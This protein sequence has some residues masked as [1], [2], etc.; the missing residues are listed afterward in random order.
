MRRQIFACLLGSLYTFIVVRVFSLLRGNVT[1]HH[2]FH[3]LFAPVQSP[4]LSDID[5]KQEIRRKTS[6]SAQ[7]RPQP[8]EKMHMPW[9][10]QT[11]V[12]Y[13]VPVSSPGTTPVN[14]PVQTS[15]KSWMPAE[16]ITSTRQPTSQIN[17]VV[18]NVHFS[19]VGPSQ[20]KALLEEIRIMDE[21][22]TPLPA[23]VSAAP[24]A[25]PAPKPS[26]DCGQ[27][28][29]SGKTLKTTASSAITKPP[30]APVH[31]PVE[32]LVQRRVA[33][34]AF[35]EVPTRIAVS[36]S[37]TVASSGS[38]GSSHSSCASASTSPRSSCSSLV[39]ESVQAADARLHAKLSNI[40]GH[41]Y[42]DKPVV[43]SELN[44]KSTASPPTPSI[45]GPADN[46]TQ[47]VAAP[48][49]LTVLEPVV[50]QGSLEAQFLPI[51][52]E[53]SVPIE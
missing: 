52:G 8:P 24:T 4:K 35:P 44:G 15:P 19:S 39:M 31:I 53:V 45:I 25:T 28:L 34:S 29:A 37:S 40:N 36:D 30:L 9:T 50:L 32:A 17:G 26:G 7:E 1:S 3:L 20:P 43:S 41:E 38:S 18:S 12:E 10:E 51:D 5:S 22:P 2:T 42:T 11:A 46:T 49:Y 47:S 23:Y 16:R 27:L 21:L 48:D 33:S 14:S 6:V 13:S